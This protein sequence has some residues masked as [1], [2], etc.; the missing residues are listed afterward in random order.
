VGGLQG[1]IRL[2]DLPAPPP[3]RTG[4]PWTEESPESPPALP[5]G[6]PWPLVSVTTPSFNQDQYLEE[7]IRSVLLQGYPNLEYIVIDGGSKDGSVDII[8]KYDRWITSWVSEPDQ[9]HSHGMNKGLMKSTGDHLAWIN[10]DDYL[11]PGFLTRRILEFQSQPER[12]GVIYGDVET[13]WGIEPKRW[14]RKGRSI[15]FKEMIRTA[16]VPMPQQ[17]CVWRRSVWEKV[18]FLDQK[19]KDLPDR[20]FL[21]RMC[22]HFDS[23]YSPGAVGLFRYHRGSK[24][25]YESDVWLNE[26]PLLYREIFD[27]PDFPP[28]L[29]YLRRESLSSAYI[30]CA[31]AAYGTGRRRRA[32]GFAL[33]A[34]LTYPRLLLRGNEIYTGIWKRIRGSARSS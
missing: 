14:T 17:S 9:G 15:T 18:G 5:D 32:Y 13:G 30:F 28:D 27:R 25:V 31:R 34:I 29:Q 20:E 12:V 3:D 2:A 7:C 16:S 22:I 21:T 24:S 4:W 23:V 33:H 8:R 1:R 10:S 11:Y 19:W 6:R 26:I